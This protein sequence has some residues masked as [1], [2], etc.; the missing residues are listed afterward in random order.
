MPEWLEADMLW[1]SVGTGELAQRSASRTLVED[2]IRQAEDEPLR[3]KIR[4]GLVLGGERFAR[5]VRRRIRMHRESEGQRT[6][7]RRW[8]FE[9]IVSKVERF[10]RESWGDFRDRYG[11]SGRDLTLWAGRRY[12][13]LTLAELGRAADEMDYSAV[14]MAIRRLEIRARR[15]KLLRSAMQYLKTECAK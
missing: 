12:G 15:D 1:R 9:E 3:G 13:G 6:L 4:W 7:S 5:Q 2:R 10:K 8:T 14:A 11:D